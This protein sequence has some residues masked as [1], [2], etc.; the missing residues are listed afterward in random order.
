VALVVVIQ[1]GDRQKQAKGY[2]DKQ[3]RKSMLPNE[4]QEDG[5][6]EGVHS[7]SGCENGLS[8]EGF[9]V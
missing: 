5:Q 1:R 4:L 7:R 9:A 8:S 6:S 3:R 2:K